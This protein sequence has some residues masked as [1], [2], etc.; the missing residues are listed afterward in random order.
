DIEYWV[1]LKAGSEFA[2]SKLVKKYFNL[3][4]NYA[5]KF[6]QD[7]DFVKD[8]VQEVFIEIWQRR[9]RISVPDSVKAYLLGSVRSKIFREISRQK[10]NRDDFETNLE[11][12]DL[13]LEESFELSLIKQEM[14]SELE[15]KVKN[16]LDSLPERQREVLYLQYYQ[17]LSRE[18]IAQIMNI[19]AQS[20]SNLSQRAFKILREIL[21]VIFM[22]WAIYY[23]S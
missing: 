5:Y 11:D 20:V 1:Q 15:K 13:L 9:D 21:G 10:I 7:K 8:C 6:N 22:F 17:N 19:N 18:E 12:N 16:S 4:Q 23:K 2:L 14:A 3:L